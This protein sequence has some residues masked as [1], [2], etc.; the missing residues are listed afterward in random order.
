MLGPHRV[1]PRT[2]SVCEFRLLHV[3]L[4][5]YGLEWFLAVCPYLSVL[6]ELGWSGL[7]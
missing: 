6:T 4:G 1:R 2:R 3:T 7:I 5:I